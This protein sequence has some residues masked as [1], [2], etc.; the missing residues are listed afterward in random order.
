MEQQN[1]NGNNQM[2]KTLIICGSILAVAVIALVCIMILTNQK[3]PNQAEMLNGG[4]LMDPSEMTF[5]EFCMGMKKDLPQETMNEVKRLYE[6]L[7]KAFEDEDMDKVNEVYKELEQL[8]VYDFS[9]FEDMG[10]DGGVI[11]MDE[12]GNVSIPD[13]IPDEIIEQ[14]EII[15]ENMGQ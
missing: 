14:I 13:E 5:E 10:L 11:I 12:N 6:V 2:K 3:T 7:Q 4:M 1:S 8:D 15:K 9:Q